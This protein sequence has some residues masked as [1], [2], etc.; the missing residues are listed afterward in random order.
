MQF[1]ICD[2]SVSDR[3][4]LDRMVRS[5]LA[6]K[7][8]KANI[9]DFA[10]A[11]ML[12]GAFSPGAFDVLFLDIYMPGI[13]G[14][15]A[16]EAIRAKDKDILLVFTTASADHA[17]ESYAVHAAGYLL[18]PFSARQLD[19]TID[20]CIENQMENSL[21]ITVTSNR[22][23]VSIAHKDI[24]YVEVFRN[25]CVIHAFSG[26]ITTNRGLTE[27]ERELGDAFL[28]CHRCY[29]VNMAHI[30]RHE[31]ACFLLPNDGRVL[32][33]RDIASKVKQHYFEWSLRNT[34]E[35]R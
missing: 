18:K 27:I 21:S 23:A 26:P 31:G 24:L 2:D 20:W 6:R 13:D 30:L 17:I 34:W 22:E 1:G 32:I 3:R 4:I 28:R 33:A 10:N 7:G 19:E 15:R 5:S 25:S 29:L 16:A 12:L 9:S 8:L 35:S 11:R 14:I